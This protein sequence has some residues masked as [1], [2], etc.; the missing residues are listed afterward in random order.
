VP[1]KRPPTPRPFEPSVLARLFCG[2]GQERSH[3][4]DESSR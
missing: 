3:E 2:A 4:H 1:R